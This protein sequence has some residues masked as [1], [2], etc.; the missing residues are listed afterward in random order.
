LQDVL[1]LGSEH[2]LNT[3]GTSEG[4]WQWRFGWNMVREDHFAM[5]KRFVAVYGRKP[6]DASD[7]ETP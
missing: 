3:P 6:R 7:A 1:A 5:L 2:R 4:N